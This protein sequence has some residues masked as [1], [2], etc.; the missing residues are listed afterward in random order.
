MSGPGVGPV[1]G[2]DRTT[3]QT[4]LLADLA[5]ALPGADLEPYG[6]VTHP[7]FMDGWSDL[8]VAI[9]C[10][11]AFDVEEVLQGRLWAF[12]S[13][14]DA[15]GQVLRAVLV[16]GRRVD[17]RIRGPRAAL[18]PPPPDN[19]IRFDAALSAVRLGRGSHL[20]GLHLLLGVLR[21]ALVH[22][23]VAADR[24]TGTTHH[25][26]ST[27]FDADAAAVLEAIGEPLGPQTALAVY[28]LHGAWRAATEPA[29]TPDPAGL[30]AVIERARG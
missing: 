14:T 28:E 4:D 21:D 17:L 29:F 25:R 26:E 27:G 10:R 9:T 6:S 23:M 5:L 1:V 30:Q 15:E 7:S 19:S 22:R 8:D 11:S 3:W 18:P 16:D 24:A 20:I 13:T 12:Q 2:P